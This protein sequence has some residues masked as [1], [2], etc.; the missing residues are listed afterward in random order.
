TY[1]YSI[2]PTKATYFSRLPRF[3][4]LDGFLDESFFS[5]ANA[6]FED[7]AAIIKD[8][9]EIFRLAEE[10]YSTLG[11][12]GYKSV[13]DVALVA[14]MNGIES[15]G[16]CFEIVDLLQVLEKMRKAGSRKIALS[17]GKRIGDPFHVLIRSTNR[18]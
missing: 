17:G 16:A 9:G 15:D 13:R 7:N 14:G 11:S 3:D 8:Q 5:F 18:T 2:E 10:A 12:G 4:Q 1:E 6:L